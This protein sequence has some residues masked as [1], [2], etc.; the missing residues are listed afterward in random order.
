MCQC[1]GAQGGDLSAQDYQY[2]AGGLGGYTKGEIILSKNFRLFVYVGMKGSIKNE[3]NRSFNGGGRGAQKDGICASGGGATD[4]R[5]I[6]GDYDNFNSIKSRIMV[7][8]GGAGS[9]RNYLAGAA[10]GLESYASRGFC[11]ATQ[12]SGY[13]L[14]LGE[15]AD[16]GINASGGGG[17]YT[18]GITGNMIGMDKNDYSSGALNSSGG[19]SFISG[20]SGCNAIIYE[21]TIIAKRAIY[22]SNN[23][24][25]DERNEDYDLISFSGDCTLKIDGISYT[26]TNTIMIDGQ[27]YSWTT[28]KGKKLGMPNPEGHQEYGHIGNGCAKITWV[29]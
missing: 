1:W 8:G 26:F 7:A 6:F 10:G 12:T 22:Y 9:E 29:L 24:Y 14:N 11:Y 27:G 16:L 13:R 21:K 17:G 23:D 5:I 18:G 4:L 3:A 28:L 15:D 19:T 20:H 2:N 25:T